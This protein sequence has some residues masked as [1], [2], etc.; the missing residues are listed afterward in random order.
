MVQFKCLNDLIIYFADPKVCWDYLEQRFWK[1]E[2]ICPHCKSYKAYRLKN[3]KQFKCAN[4]ATCDKKFTVLTGT[5]FENTKIPLQKWIAAIYI[6]TQHKKG[7][8]SLQLARDL[9]VTQ[10]TS[11]FMAHRIRKMVTQKEKP[12]LKEKVIIDE[13]YCGGSITNMNK[14]KRKLIAEVFN[15]ER[16]QLW[17]S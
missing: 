15:P 6:L 12:K 13:T 1:G 4:K 14:Y 5:I 7:I 3:Y 8:S 16:L 11:W 2:P 9:G 10:K 17:D